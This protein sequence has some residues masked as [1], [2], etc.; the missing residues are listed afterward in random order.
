MLTLVASSSSWTSSWSSSHVFDFAL[1]WDT[2]PLACLWA[3]ASKLRLAAVL[4]GVAFVLGAGLFTHYED[5]SFIDALYLTTAVM[6][7]IGYGDIS[8]A[9]DA[10]KATVVV[11]SVT[12]V[13]VLGLLIDEMAESA[14]ARVKFVVD[15][16]SLPKG[17]IDPYV[18]VSAADRAAIRVSCWR[19]AY[20]AAK[21]A[22]CP[23]VLASP[24]WQT[25]VVRGSQRPMWDAVF[26]IPRAFTGGVREGVT[27]EL[28]DWDRV[29]ADDLVGTV[30]IPFHGRAHNLALPADVSSSTSSSSSV[31]ETQ[32]SEWIDVSCDLELTPEVAAS[33]AV[34]EQLALL[35]PR[36]LISKRLTSTHMFLRVVGADDLPVTDSFAGRDALYN[37]FDA[38]KEI[39]VAF[40]VF[41][42]VVLGFGAIFYGL[43]EWS[44]FESVYWAFVTVFTIGLGDFAPTT[45]TSRGVF[46]VF[47]VGVLAVRGYAIA[48]ATAIYNSRYAAHELFDD[49]PDGQNALAVARATG[50]PAFRPSK[51][52]QLQWCN[53]RIG[54]FMRY[55]FDAPTLS[56]IRDLLFIL[57]AL[58]ILALLSSLVTYAEDWSWFES[59]YFCV[60]LFGVGYG[61]LTPKTTAGR[62]FVIIYGFCAAILLSIAVAIV[63]KRRLSLDME[64]L[65]R[66]TSSSLSASGPD[67][68][69]STSTLALT[70]YSIEYDASESDSHD[71]ESDE[72]DDTYDDDDDE[73][74]EEE[75]ESE[76]RCQCTSATW[77]EFSHWSGSAY[78]VVAL[79]Y[80]VSNLVAAGVFYGLES[81]ITPYGNAV[82][83][84]V[85][86]SSTVGFGDLSPRTTGGRL[87]FIVFAFFSLGLYAYLLTL[88]ERASSELLEAKSSRVGLSEV[89]AKRRRLDPAVVAAT[90]R[91]NLNREKVLALGEVLAATRGALP[92]PTDWV[93]FDS[94]PSSSSPSSS[95]YDA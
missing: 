28:W 60:T 45:Q 29:N 54:G 14:L 1:P 31:S 30:Y 73:E 24:V 85:V 37:A 57:V 67:S 71:D 23:N 39:S 47:A 2:S 9:T 92:L 8:P 94:R 91:K 82:Y 5:L 25:P 43:E 51:A 69:T 65:A 17:T 78:L 3:H 49:S 52:P 48:V 4:S 62:V 74:E 33:P 55:F 83:F 81:H 44:F 79:I 18:R 63:T 70:R 7:T 42:A 50:Q 75:E 90:R 12:G 93:S 38:V 10:G 32:P 88:F 77:H 89:A 86:T 27:L 15:R 95:S 26:V 22:C 56:E 6:T 16:M 11:F 80:L 19:K 53:N 36:V 61:D 13:V 35:T 84:A 87:F 41:L 20:E 72:S 64:Q 59:V 66:M 68:D 58:I 40:L 34:V 46:L 21:W 76:Y